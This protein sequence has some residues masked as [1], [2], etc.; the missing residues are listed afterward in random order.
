MRGERSR[1]ERIVVIKNLFE[2]Q[3]FD[4]KCELILEYQNDLRDECSKCGVVR[5]VVIYDVSK[6]SFLI[7][8]FSHN[9]LISI[10]FTHVAPSRRRG[11]N[12]YVRS[13]RSRYC[14]EVVEWTVFRTT[15]AECVHMG[16]Q[17]EV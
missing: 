12:H 4:A 9:N 10:T 7:D 16:W 6:R 8:W 3:L 1:D 15:A 17:R 13:R 14:C 5:K 11:A 2:P